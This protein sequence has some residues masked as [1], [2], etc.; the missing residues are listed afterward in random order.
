MTTTSVTSKG[1]VTIPKQV[2]ELLG[3]T[4]GSRLAFEVEGSSVRIRL[5]QPGLS[6]RVEDGPHILDYSG[7]RIATA[8]LHGGCAMKKA[9]ARARR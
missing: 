7:P 8:K 5:V 3:I 9:A 4:A 6:S 1:Q 2:R